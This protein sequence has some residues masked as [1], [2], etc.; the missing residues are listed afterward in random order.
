[1]YKNVD[2]GLATWK[3][4]KHCG[5]LFCQKHVGKFKVHVAKC[6]KDDESVNGDGM[7]GV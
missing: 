6:N 3:K 5:C 7:V 4:C 2:V 1:M